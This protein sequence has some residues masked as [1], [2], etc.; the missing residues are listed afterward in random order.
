MTQ[1]QTRV[2]TVVAITLLALALALALLGCAGST[3]KGLPAGTGWQTGL[4]APRPAVSAPLGDFSR[5]LPPQAYAALESIGMPVSE[6]QR[7]VPAPVGK[8][9]SVV[10]PFTF[11]ADRVYSAGDAGYIGSAHTVFSGPPFNTADMSPPGAGFPDNFSYVLYRIDDVLEVPSNLTLSFGPTLPGQ[12]IGVAAY[13]FAYGALGRWEPLYYGTADLGSVDADMSDPGWDFTNGGDDLAFI[14]FCL[15]PSQVSISSVMLGGGGGG[16]NDPPMAALRANPDSS[17]VTFT[18]TLDAGGSFDPDGTIANY[19]FDA[20][21]DGNWVDN[22][23]VS[24]LD[25]K[26]TGPGV[27]KAQVEVMDNLGAASTA[28]VTVIAAPVL[29]SEIEDNDDGTQANPLPG[30]QFS[31]F[32]GNIGLGGNYDGDE[33]DWFTFSAD[34]GDSVSF[35]VEF[36][37]SADADFTVY[38]LDG[39][40]NDLAPPSIGFPPQRLNY[41]FDGTENGPFYLAILNFSGVPTNY[42]IEGD[43]A[44]GGYDEVENNDSA[45]TANWWALLEVNHQMINYRA[46]LGDPGYDSDNDDWFFFSGPSG[47]VVDL[48]LDYDIDTGKIGFTLFDNDGDM[49]A[50]SADGDGNEQI[51]YLLQPADTMP[52]RVHCAVLG[53]FS[54]YIANGSITP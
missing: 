23:A 25:H 49:L 17:Q 20:L 8:A 7:G 34:A 12:S 14:A 53:G 6:Q 48:T 9:A 2:V 33:A 47:S 26:Y 51:S 1:Q 15:N 29:Y 36:A 16:P 22:G 5:V 32:A 21:G 44:V 3:S 37:Q 31:D 27:Y 24:T 42:F 38:L 18:A 35:L 46:S 52:L 30:I 41:N 39:G 19:R 50:N 11:E 4:P 43:D 10:L 40:L 54:D 45:D 28:E 13:N